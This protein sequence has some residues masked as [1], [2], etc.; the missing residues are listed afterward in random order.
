M[1]YDN[2]AYDLS[3]FETHSSAAP[4][5]EP[6]KQPRLREIKNPNARTKRRAKPAKLVACGILLFAMMAVHVG[7]NAVMTETRAQVKEEEA[8]LVEAQNKENLLD[9]EL[10]KMLNME[11]VDAFAKD[12]LGLCKPERYQIEY[13][14]DRNAGN[15]ITV[16]AEEKTF[17]DRIA[18]AFAGLA[19]AFS[20]S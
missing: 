15:R 9:V 5:E 17:W 6:K 4:K 7:N 11:N 12:K 2:S 8:L 13:L 14:T 10:D 20:G 18:D 19:S 3:L 1:A 16:Q